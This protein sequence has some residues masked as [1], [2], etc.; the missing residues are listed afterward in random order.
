M[1]ETI[2]ASCQG[3]WFSKKEKVIAF[4]IFEKNYPYRLVSTVI[5]KY[6]PELVLDDGETCR[7]Q[8]TKEYNIYNIGE[9]KVMG[10]LADY[11]KIA[12]W[13]RDD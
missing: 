6:K 2:V 5:E 12:Q 10:I 13:E 7:K 11:A 4:N 1:R 3:K 9:Y 8:S